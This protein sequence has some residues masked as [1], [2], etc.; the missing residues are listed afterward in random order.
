M[1]TYNQSWSY[2]NKDLNKRAS[3]E[4]KKAGYKKYVDEKLEQYNV[5]LISAD[6]Y[7]EAVRSAKIL[8][9]A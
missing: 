8:M 4:S 3:L 9:V 6:E 1:T 5:G 2:R 7:Y